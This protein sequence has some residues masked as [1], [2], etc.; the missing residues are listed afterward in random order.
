[1][2]I[3][4]DKQGGFAQN[5]S[6]PAFYTRFPALEERRAARDKFARKCFNCGED[7]RFAPDC[8]KLFM[9]VSAPTN[10]DVG[11]GNAIETEK[12]WPKC[13]ARLKKY[14]TDRV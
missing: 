13:E 4:L 14:Y 8:P 9:D 2:N 7:T 6:D 1:M 3:I 12:K 5:H 11:S 10:P